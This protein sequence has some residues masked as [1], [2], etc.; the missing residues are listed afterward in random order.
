MRIILDGKPGDSS[1]LTEHCRHMNGRWYSSAKSLPPNLQ[2]YAYLWDGIDPEKLAVKPPVAP[3]KPAKQQSAH[4]R[5]KAT[6]AAIEKKVTPVPT[7]DPTP[8]V[9]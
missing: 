7:V 5:A 2:D 1:Q 9:E 8:I 6:V 4:D 3:T